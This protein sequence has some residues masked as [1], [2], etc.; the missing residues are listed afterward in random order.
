M[1]NYSPEKL[2]LRMEEVM[3]ENEAIRVILEM[4]RNLYAWGLG[5]V[6][7]GSVTTNA[8]GNLG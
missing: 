1:Y 7:I 5:S 8:V 4:G 3:S 2:L 6:A